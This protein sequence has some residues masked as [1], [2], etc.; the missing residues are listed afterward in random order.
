MILLLEELF[1]GDNF[2][3]I[4]SIF[5]RTY[6]SEETYFKYSVRI[7]FREFREKDIVPVAMFFRMRLKTG[8]SN[9]NQRQVKETNG[10]ILS[11]LKFEFELNFCENC[12]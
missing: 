1:F 11:S 6:F 9:A 12:F 2:E 5:E 8:F 4:F 3:N 10:D 7:K